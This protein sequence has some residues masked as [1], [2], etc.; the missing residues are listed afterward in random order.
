MGVE[1]RPWACQRDGTKR[2][3]ANAPDRDDE[4]HHSPAV[5]VAVAGEGTTTTSVGVD[6][7]GHPSQINPTTPPHGRDYCRDRRSRGAPGGTESAGGRSWRSQA[8]Y[9]EVCLCFVVYRFVRKYKNLF[10]TNVNIKTILKFEYI[11]G[12]LFTRAKHAA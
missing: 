11:V 10:N 6:L 2:S 7:A 3:D 4:S 12:P 5:V 1:R 9:L 8:S